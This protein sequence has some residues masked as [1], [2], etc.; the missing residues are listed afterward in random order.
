MA[1][2]DIPTTRRKCLGWFTADTLGLANGASVTSWANRASGGWGNLVAGGCT[3]QTGALNGQG[4]VNIASGGLIRTPAVTAG[5]NAESTILAVWCATADGEAAW[6]NSATY[7]YSVLRSSPNGFGYGTSIAKTSTNQVGGG[8]SWHI[9]TIRHSP[10]ANNSVYP[11][12][13]NTTLFGVDLC[14]VICENGRAGPTVGNT[15]DIPRTGAMKIAE[16]VIFDRALMHEELMEMHR[17]LAAKWGLYFAGSDPTASAIFWQGNSTTRYSA[18]IASAFAQANRDLKMIQVSEAVDGTG[19]KDSHAQGGMAEQYASHALTRKLAPILVYHHGHNDAATWNQDALADPAGS[20]QRFRRAGGRVMLH[21]P[22]VWN[23]N[24]SVKAQID[25]LRTW[26]LANWPTVADGVYDLGGSHEFGVYDDGSA[27]PGSSRG[28][29]PGNWL[30]LVHPSLAGQ[31][32]KATL[33]SPSM[34]AMMGRASVTSNLP[35]AVTVAHS[36]APSGWSYQWY[37]S[38]ATF[39]PLDSVSTRGAALSGATAQT[40]IDTTADPQTLYAY[41]CLMTHATQGAA[42]SAPVYLTTKAQPAR[43][44]ARLIRSR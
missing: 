23:N 9:A 12:C 38:T 4:V 31:Q 27:P 35:A 40:L 37:R 2:W 33:I 16:L 5:L 17:Y 39:D 29:F 26:I 21:T 30:D 15:I 28:D 42:W 1:I 43:K 11:G 41:A 34:R 14:D 7:W 8:N 18:G 44:R 24:L 25:A 32:A 22:S 6:D 19:S 36:G 13:D 20:V 10:A 3:Y